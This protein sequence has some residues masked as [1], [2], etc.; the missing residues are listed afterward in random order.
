VGIGKPQAARQ[1][2]RHDKRSTPDQSRHSSS[3][4]N[5]YDRPEASALAPGSV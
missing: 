2:K 1:S 5:D 3:F 4:P